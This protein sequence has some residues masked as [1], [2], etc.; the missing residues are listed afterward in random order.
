MGLKCMNSIFL[1]ILLIKPVAKTFKPYHK[2]SNYNNNRGSLV[3][4]FW[5]KLLCGVTMLPTILKGLI[6][7]MA[8][9]KSIYSKLGT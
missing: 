3:L 2:L 8:A 6:E 5:F 9:V 1:L 4:I 7:E